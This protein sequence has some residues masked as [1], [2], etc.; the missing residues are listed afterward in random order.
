MIAWSLICFRDQILF[1]SETHR[2]TGWFC[3]RFALPSTCTSAGEDGYEIS[4]T[5]TVIWEHQ[6]F[7]RFLIFIFFPKTS[8]LY[9]IN[10]RKNPERERECVIVIRWNKY[11]VYLPEFTWRG[12]FRN[13]IWRSWYSKVRRWIM[14]WCRFESV[15]G[16]YT[17]AGCRWKH[18]TATHVREGG[19]GR[20]LEKYRFNGQTLQTLD[21]KHYA[22][23]FH[24]PRTSPIYIS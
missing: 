15:A 19:P 14:I 23:L 16:L 18:N 22:P 10:I 21:F 9:K 4:T 2:L 5:L 11:K 17:E 12:I 13:H 1:W 3:L 7:Y 24:D 6:L 20:D 8:Y